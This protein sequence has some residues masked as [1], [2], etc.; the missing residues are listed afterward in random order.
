MR[1]V[2]WRTLVLVLPLG[3]SVAA[4]EEDPAKPRNRDP[5]IASLTAFPGVVDPGDSLLVICESADADGDLLVYDWLTDGR[6]QIKGNQPGDSDLS[7]SPSKTQIFH[8]V[9]S[10]FD[11][12][13]VE[14]MVRD[15]RGGN[16]VQLVTI[17]INI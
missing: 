10:A 2:P 16:D 3:L 6:L 1:R 9:T 11:S 12:A 5:V 8:V 14:C 7:N 15:Q 4:C 17:R 13:W